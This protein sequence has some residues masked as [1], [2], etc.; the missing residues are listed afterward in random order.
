[1]S[2]PF[3]CDLTAIPV[4]LRAAHHQLTRRLMD[5]VVQEVREVP[6]GL[7][8]RFA[9]EEYDGVAEFVRLE[10]LCCPFLGFALELSPDRGPL[11]LHLT[12]PEGVKDFIRT[13]LHLPSV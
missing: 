4:R 8:F 13:E 10:R 11:I 7:E 3:A 6:D 2:V 5:D 9:A 1:M 12:G